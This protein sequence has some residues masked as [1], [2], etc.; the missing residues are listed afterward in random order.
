MKHQTCDAL[1]K[2]HISNQMLHDPAYGWT[3]KSRGNITFKGS[4]DAQCPADGTGMLLNKYSG[5]RKTQLGNGHPQ[6]L[7]QKMTRS[8]KT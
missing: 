7:L 3:T 1:N 4:E 6:N 8:I 5:Y 2:K